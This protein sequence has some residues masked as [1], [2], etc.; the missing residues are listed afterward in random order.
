MDFAHFSMAR[1]PRDVRSERR[2]RFKET[3]TLKECHGWMYLKDNFMDLQIEDARMNL[4]I[5]IFQ[6]KLNKFV[7][8]VRKSD[9][10]Y[11]VQKQ[12]LGYLYLLKVSGY[13]HLLTQ[14]CGG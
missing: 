13:L 9:K 11:N 4:G 7:I 2:S 8:T 10:F 5:Q 3:L 1:I 14:Y 6:G 12:H